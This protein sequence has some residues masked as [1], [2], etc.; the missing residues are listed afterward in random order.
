MTDQS[1]ADPAAI[2]LGLLEDRA[3]YGTHQHAQDIHSLIAAV[4]ALQE[5]VEILEAEIR[6]MHKLPAALDAA[7]DKDGP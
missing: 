4:V 7:F 6:A 1:P 2:D 5:R 3:H